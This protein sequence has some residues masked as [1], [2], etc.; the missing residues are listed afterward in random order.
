[1]QF[2]GGSAARLAGAGQPP[3]EARG[4]GGRASQP[5]PRDAVRT[6]GLGRPHRAATGLTIH[7]PPPR[8]PA[9]A[10]EQVECPFFALG[11]RKIATMIPRELRPRLVAII[12][13]AAG[14]SGCAPR[15]ETCIKNAYIMYDEHAADLE[16]PSARRVQFIDAEIGRVRFVQELER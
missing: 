12:A 11:S 14:L 1:G 13:T 16:A 3:R 9:E 4:A 6:R 15:A 5:Y 10:G 2:A 7:A 8:P